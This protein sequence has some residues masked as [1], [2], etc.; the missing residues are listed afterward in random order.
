M[1]CSPVSS[2]KRC[3]SGN[4][5]VCFGFERVVT[6]Q[7]HA[8]MRGG[9]FIGHEHTGDHGDGGGFTGNVATDQSVEGSGG[10]YPGLMRSTATFWPNA[11]VRPRI[12]MAGRRQCRYS[13]RVTGSPV[14]H[15][16]QLLRG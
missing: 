11:L 2:S 9:A 10:G 4:A 13:L 15:R 8:R 6:C 16:E 5:Q 12:S 3:P 1:S 14:L 7:Y